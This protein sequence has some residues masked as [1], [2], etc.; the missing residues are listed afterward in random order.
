MT[1]PPNDPDKQSR[2]PPA[3]CWLH[4]ALAVTFL[5]R[6]PL[7]VSR[8]VRPEDMRAS[9]GW[10]PCVGIG[11]GAVGWALFREGQFVFAPLLSAALVIVLLEML[12]GALHLDGF[13]DTC[14]GLGSGAQRERALEIMKDPRM[15]AMG[16]FGGVAIILIKVAALSALTPSQAL[17]PL[18]IGWMAARVIPVLDVSFFP[19][20]RPA[21]TGAAFTQ[22]GSRTM[23]VLALITVLA[24]GWAIKPAI[25]LPFMAGIMGVT[26]L[27]QWGASRKLGGLTGDVYG[28]GIEM[29]ETMA[30]ILGCILARWSFI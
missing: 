3:T 20:A 4:F 15:G 18:L 8:A 13:M 7:P 30:L 24:F 14:D 25:A 2:T 17:L 27:V 10:Y 19:Y 29:T 9:M 28:L 23:L 12:S 5:T 11:L 21:G 1:N 22:G 26:L 6:I 16:V